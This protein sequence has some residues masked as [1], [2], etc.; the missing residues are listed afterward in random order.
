VA[1]AAAREFARV[2]SILRA[3]GTVFVAAVFTL[4]FVA[5]FQEFME[6][7]APDAL[8]VVV[9]NALFVLLYVTRSNPKSVSVSPS[10]WALSVAGTTL[11]LLMRPSAGG[12]DSAGLALQLVGLVLIVAALISL[13]RS[14][15]I[16][17]ANRGVRER[18]LYRFVRHPLYAGEIVFITGFVLANPSA[19]N[20]IVWVFECALQVCRARVEERFLNADPQYRSYCQRTRYR[21]LPLVF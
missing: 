5:C 8:G 6:T 7:R 19:W 13:S 1:L 3:A 21:L 2:M 17:P 16:V 12:F 14:F 20:V 10:E 4:M 9:V 18:G 15:G 11:P